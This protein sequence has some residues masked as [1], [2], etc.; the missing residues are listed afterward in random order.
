MHNMDDS[1]KLLTMLNVDSARPTKRQRS[2][3]RDWH[4]IAKKARAAAITTNSKAPVEPAPSLAAASDSDDEEAEANAKRDSFDLHWSH[5]SPLV[6]GK[7]ADELKE[8]KWRKT[9]KTLREFGE[10]TEWLP[11]N[12][13][14][15]EVK[16]SSIVSVGV[17]KGS[18]SSH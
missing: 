7:S 14:P 1:T 4:Q 8:I 6:E 15:S 5:D 3:A 10:S 11:Q 16:D 18:I 17:Y 13:E 2:S 12:A 9:K